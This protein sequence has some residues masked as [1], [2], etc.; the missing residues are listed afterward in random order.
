M[1]RR[2]FCSARSLRGAKEVK[3]L[4]VILDS[5]RDMS[6]NDA[7]NLLFARFIGIEKSIPVNVFHLGQNL[8]IS[9]DEARQID[10]NIKTIEKLEIPVEKMTIVPSL[11][12]FEHSVSEVLDKLHAKQLIKE[13]SNKRTLFQIPGDSIRLN[14]MKIGDTQYDHREQITSQRFYIR[15]SERVFNPNFLFSVA[16]YASVKQPIVVLDHETNFVQS[17]YKSAILEHLDYP[18]GRFL[19]TPGI[20]HVCRLC[21]QGIGRLPARQTDH[22]GAIGGD[23]CGQSSLGQLHWPLGL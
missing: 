22:V 19:H 11:P 3:S 8:D 13:T 15:K 5:S 4:G 6:I 21:Y 7:R 16:V 2:Q 12:G 17:L 23:W 20:L 18:H 9:A 1:L 10:R 14:D